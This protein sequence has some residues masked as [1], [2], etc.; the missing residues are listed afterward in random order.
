MQIY[1]DFK[2]AYKMLNKKKKPFEEKNPYSGM[3]EP[4]V[5]VFTLIYYFMKDSFCWN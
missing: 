3:N 4:H 5:Y 2:V 1:E